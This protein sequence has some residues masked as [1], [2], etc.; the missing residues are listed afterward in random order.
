MSMRS[1]MFAAFNKVSEYVFT[2]ASDAISTT[3]S[4]VGETLL[5]YAPP[6]R[7]RVLY[8]TDPSLFSG[9]AEREMLQAEQA[10]EDQRLEEVEAEKRRLDTERGMLR[11]REMRELAQ[12]KGEREALRREETIRRRV[13]EEAE[14][15][16]LMV[17]EN[18]TRLFRNTEERKERA[19]QAR[20]ETRKRLLHER[21][22]ARE[23]PPLEDIPKELPPHDPRVEDYEGKERESDYDEEEQKLPQER[24]ED[25]FLPP[26]V[27]DDLYE[28]PNYEDYLAFQMGE[29]LESQNVWSRTL[30]NWDV[31]LRKI[32]QAGRRARMRAITSVEELRA[33]QESL[34]KAKRKSDVLSSLDIANG[35]IITANL[36][37]EI[38]KYRPFGSVK[39]VSRYL[40][41]YEYHSIPNPAFYQ[42]EMTLAYGIMY[43]FIIM[44]TYMDMKN[45]TVAIKFVKPATEHTAEEVIYKSI[46]PTSL[47]QVL[48]E[49]RL[50]QGQFVEGVTN[51][52]DVDY[53]YAYELDLDSFL[54]ESRSRTAPRAGVNPF[55][56]DGDC[57]Y[58]LSQ[59]G[60]IGELTLLGDNFS[61]FSPTCNGDNCILSAC[62]FLNGKKD[63]TM[64]RNSYA[65]VRESLN[66]PKKGLIPLSRLSDIAKYFNINIRAYNVV[67]NGVG[68][69]HVEVGEF[70]GGDR[71]VELLFTDILTEQG[72]CF[73]IRRTQPTPPRDRKKAPSKVFYKTHVLGFDF[74]TVADHRDRGNLKT[75]SVSF[76][77]YPLDEAPQDFADEIKNVTNITGTRFVCEK[78]LVDYVL[79]APGDVKYV[80]VGFNSS[81][82]DNFFLA[83]QFACQSRLD[84]V[85]I[86]NNE[87]KGFAS[88]RH[89]TL[90]LCKIAV[91]TLQGLCS[92]Y[93]TSPKKLAGFD[94]R[95][96]QNAFFKGG[97]EKLIEWVDEN[98][99]LLEEYNAKDV[100]SML[101]LLEKV[102]ASLLSLTGVDFIKQNVGTIG[103]VTE[104]GWIAKMK[105]LEKA[106]GIDYRPQAANEEWVDEMMRASI[107]GGRT[108]NMK[109]LPWASTESM[110]M[111]DAKSLYPTAMMG[112]NADSLHERNTYGFF[113]YDSY[114]FLKGLDPRYAISVHH[115]LILEQPSSYDKPK[116]VIPRREKDKPL[117][118]KYTG[119]FEAVLNSV[120]IAQIRA[121]GGVVE[122]YAGFGY[123]KSTDLTFKDFLDR[124][125]KAKDEQDVYKN[126][127]NPLYNAAIRE[128]A[129]LLMNSLSGKFNQKNHTTMS[130][131]VKNDKD[132]EEAFDTL[133][134]DEPYEYFTLTQTIS[135]LS[136]KKKNELIYNPKKAR[137][138]IISSLIYSYARQ[139]MYDNLLYPYDTLYGDTDSAMLTKQEYDRFRRDKP[140]LHAEAQGREPEL[141]DFEEELGANDG[142]N[143]CVV[144]PKNYLGQPLIRAPDGTMVINHANV[145]CK[146][147]GVGM[148]SAKRILD[149][150]ITLTDMSLEQQDELFNTPSESVIALYENK[151]VPVIKNGK[152]VLDVEGHMLLEERGVYVVE[153]L[154]K[155]LVEKGSVRIMC[156]QMKRNV[157]TLEI[158]NSYVIKTIT[159]K[160]SELTIV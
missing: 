11:L 113:P 157:T 77:S 95:L 121:H 43:A 24:K 150:T 68:C 36:S 18:A 26:P 3:M 19:L 53:V 90:D 14:R 126:S 159:A 125:I 22:E 99:V 106:T 82:F 74:E 108:E 119:S 114:D 47:A 39:H 64:T 89:R 44:R 54:I 60:L 80:M 2:R 130:F 76:F 51:G 52:S 148:K 69:S 9:T 65:K 48:T 31:G 29:S 49:I 37:R 116:I 104:K 120:D 1:R 142:C 5:Y 59:L 149:P 112:K 135:I 100:L 143:T 152:V 129:K 79:A 124:L 105:E 158:F 147:K 81:R 78:A 55:K 84:S 10:E 28:F 146:L 63:T 46:A 75:Y 140:K 97:E 127:K 4:R 32:D 83:K 7:H 144:A 93:K 38:V 13:A 50:L 133:D 94:H 118:W 141:G 71:T 61:L 16:V 132:E 123:K 98:R 145:K 34:K 70:E 35:D 160:V 111:V 56:K 12:L 137:A 15:E 115:V 45:A 41:E 155:D 139:Y 96:P 92:S 23:I 66:L 110:M 138:S 67:D 128:T 136:G 103:S 91:G 151:K 101:D 87:L 57:L 6:M 109:G 30:R 73:A 88:G 8:E 42:N 85:F 134:I 156:F 86:A 107:Y 17:E 40:K 102:R 72:H 62:S 153:D 33:E 117:D 27:N 20:K 25:Q 122:V 21:R 131:L 154:F 58:R